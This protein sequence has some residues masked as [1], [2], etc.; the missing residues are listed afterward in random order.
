LSYGIISLSSELLWDKGAGKG[1]S[2][3]LGVAAA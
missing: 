3:E 2:R 1:C